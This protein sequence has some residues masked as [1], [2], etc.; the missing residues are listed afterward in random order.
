MTSYAKNIIVYGAI[1]GVIGTTLTV[2]MTRPSD[3]EQCKRL[4]REQNTEISEIKSEEVQQALRSRSLLSV[5]YKATDNRGGYT[6]TE[7]RIE[8]GKAKLTTEEH[9]GPSQGF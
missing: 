5:K 3:E 9:P 6:V 1:A 4:A 7:C 8:N 2:T